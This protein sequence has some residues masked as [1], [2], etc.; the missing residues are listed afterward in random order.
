MS[1]TFG[2][3]LNPRNL[4]E[5]E[6]EEIRQ[7]IKDFHKDYWVIQKGTYYRLTDERKE[8]WYTAWEI[9]S[10]DQ[11]QAIVNLV[12]TDIHANPEFPYVK[13]RGLKKQ[14]LYRLEDW[15]VF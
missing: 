11:T 9:V 13:V 6:K 5:Q 14:S 3:E 4:T 10:E 8:S 7:Q 15:T 12:V 2:Y 1:G